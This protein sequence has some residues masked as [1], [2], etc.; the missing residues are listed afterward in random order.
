MDAPS[1]EPEEKVQS[2]GKGRKP[3]VLTGNVPEVVIFL[4]TNVIRARRI[5]NVCVVA[6]LLIGIA[7]LGAF[8]AFS[9]AA[10]QQRYE[11]DEK[12][13]GYLD[14]RR[15]EAREKILSDIEETAAAIAKI[16]DKSVLQRAQSKF[17]ELISAFNRA[18]PPNYD[19]ERGNNLA[20]EIVYNF[21]SSVIRIGAVL[22]G[23]YLI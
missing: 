2:L 7:I 19:T 18:M 6:T 16:E 13:F 10:T 1:P 20:D 4:K 22:I 23:I 3:S 9:Q 5:G 12:M 14:N 17:D 21:T 11:R 15:Q 8:L